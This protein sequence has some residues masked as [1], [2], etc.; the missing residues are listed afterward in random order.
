MLLT[1]RMLCLLV[2]FMLA[3][4][5]EGREGAA[6]EGDKTSGSSGHTAAQADKAKPRN[7]QPQEGAHAASTASKTD[8][9]GVALDLLLVSE[10]ELDDTNAISLLFNAPLD[11]DQ[12]FISGVNTT[13]DLGSPF[14]SPDGKTLYFNGIKPDTKYKVSFT[15]TIKAQNG[16]QYK[17]KATSSLTTRSMP[18][19]VSFESQGAILRPGGNET[20]PVL[21]QNVSDADLRIYRVRHEK[22]AR[23]FGAYTRLAN[24]D[25][26]YI[27]DLRNELLTETY[28]GRVHLANKKN[29]RNQ[30]DIAL[31]S[32]G[33]SGRKGLY[34][35]VVGQAGRFGFDSA[36][37]F[38]VSSLGMQLR[39][40][41]KSMSLVVQDIDG[42]E[43]VAD[44]SI[45][46]FKTAKRG[47]KSKLL[48]LRSD[49]E[50]GV[51]NEKGMYQVKGL[52]NNKRD[53]L[54]VATLG[55]QVSVLPYKE[56]KLDLS[57]YPI[58]GRSYA[59][60]E[61]FL[62]GPRDIYRPGEDLTV[63]ILRRDADGGQVPGPLRL[64]VIKPDASVYKSI[65]LDP[66]HDGYF[67]LE[68]PL[69]TNSPLGQWHADV[70][71]AAGKKRLAR[72]DFKVEEFLPERLRLEFENSSGGDVKVL[73]EYLYGAPAA[74]NAMDVRVTIRPW[75]SP[76][77]QHPG[78]VFGDEPKQPYAEEDLA[79]LTLDDAGKQTLSA[80]ALS[81][82]KLKKW[83]SPARLSYYC[84]LYESGGRA[85]NRRH[86]VLW[87]PK[88]S[89]IGIKPQFKNDRSSENSVAAFDVLRSNSAGQVLGSGQAKVS[90]IRH[91]KNYY[92][93]NTNDGWGYQADENE[94]VV[95]QQVIDFSEASKQTLE[96]PVEWGNYRL[97]IHDLTSQAD[98]V[99][100]FQAGSSWYRSWNTASSRIR[101][102]QVTLAWDQGGYQAGDTAT[103]KIAAPTAGKALVML[104][105]D[106]I[107]HQQFVDLKNN[108][109]TVSL[110]VPKDLNRH[111][112]YVSVY[113]VAP[114]TAGENVTKRSLGVIHLPLQ[115]ADRHL[116]VKIN[117]PERWRPEQTVTA[118][119]LVNNAKGQP[120]SGSAYVTLSA[121]DSG[122]LSLTDYKVSDPFDLFYAKRRYLAAI[123]DN[124][125]YVVE[126]L[127]GDKAKVLWGGDTDIQ[128]LR[129]KP[130]VDVK[131]VSLFS[132][133]VS[134]ANGVAKIPLDL[135]QFDGELTLTAVGFSG[136][137]FGKADQT[138]KVSAP[139]VAQLSKPRFLALGD[140][141][142]LALDL[143]N[144]N[145]PELNDVS[146]KYHIDGAL[147]QHHGQFDDIQLDTGKRKTFKF[148]ID[149][150][151]VGQGT[152]SVDI[153]LPGYSMR[154]TWSLNVR[155]AYPAEY[156][157]V[158]R[159]I[160]SGEAIAFPSE[161]LAGLMP[162]TVKAQIAIAQYPDLN[163]GEHLR[164]LDVYPYT[165][166]EQTSSKARP[167]ALFGVDEL[168]T[169]GLPIDKQ[170]VQEKVDTTLL[171]Y[172][173]LQRSN[174]SFGL[175]SK[176]SSEDQ[177]LTVYATELLLSLRD[178]GYE[179]P[180][181][182]LDPALARLKQYVR[183]NSVPVIKTWS[184]QPSHY[185]ASYRAYAAYVLAKEG[186]TT[187]GPVRSIA[188]NDLADA[189]GPLPSLRTGMAMIQLGAVDEG[190]KLIKTAM[191]LSR[192]SE[193]LGDYGSGVRDEAIV[194]AAVLSQQ[195]MPDGLQVQAHERLQALSHRIQTKSWLS[196]QERNAIIELGAV[197]QRVY[198]DTWSGDLATLAG[199]Q[200]L[201]GTGYKRLNIA[202]MLGDK[203]ARFVN[204]G[205]D[206]V[207][208]S[209]AWTGQRDQPPGKASNGIQIN[210]KHFVYAQGKA[211]PLQNGTELNT[212]DIVL[213][214][215]SVRSDE[216][217]PDALLVNLMPA[218]LELENQN[219]T[220]AMKLSS[221]RIEGKKL[222][223][224]HAIE[225]QEYRDDRY[226]AA[227]DLRPNDEEVVYFISRA[228]NPGQ[229][230]VPPA[231]IESMYSPQINGLGASMGSITVQGR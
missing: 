174:G 117:V 206:P 218:G 28:S 102:D 70:M 201:Q 30:V 75:A 143:T 227:M 126:R 122:V 31:D 62:Y 160:G 52:P 87:W 145:E 166:L 203:A 26:R 4:C 219:L 98:T 129:D 92:W 83:D 13:P 79:P 132:G 89:Y 95:S 182:M 103:L 214:R 189:A 37:W 167:F 116:D 107:L 194:L 151:N 18:P 82:I 48:N 202:Y 217:I 137:A 125:R 181:S 170:A 138:V 210:A 53:L 108:Q 38:T 184:N 96:L 121:V 47:N 156:H 157:R 220:H 159:S 34:F 69:P 3:A 41:Q 195:G 212:G 168:T 90:L 46:I 150:Q 193:Y 148:E 158:S 71:N 63:S 101:P 152:I 33:V 16:S 55:D 60:A 175:W 225:Y 19:G 196:P 127:L 119:V 164:Y 93:T 139:V 74:G 187:L 9:A 115:R 58:S 29:A 6:I 153:K 25:S 68:L 230:T 192:V 65:K 14:L 185:Y 50:V 155:S 76:L 133:Q 85:L 73:G 88:E 186:Q 171:R 57:E 114:T 24:P 22:V 12:D 51:T 200:A 228:I 36:T 169:F 97:K 149:A 146:V 204:T 110:P 136:S 172:A 17:S 198:T 67:E 118:K 1:K 223:N 35:A 176:S 100:A 77:E 209:Y 78:Y 134:V 154:R 61:H 56:P 226:M 213:S 222:H 207:F 94:Y 84:S 135:P 15:G 163:L 180:Q 42:G 221:I 179:V 7:N 54:F 231:Q 27:K 197:L 59:V 104:E 105:T 2:V 111:D 162:D 64:H 49:G 72:F 8:Y 147:V 141:S 91:E 190:I 211:A 229:Y 124:Y 205:K 44:A 106:R 5:G 40:N 11:P 177:W 144:L 131:I 208:V 191:G 178:A 199:E 66:Q 20:L 173:E 86:D 81:Q 109:A 165:C 80:S 113:V 43:P 140:K 21:A 128:E 215:V 112:A 123:K 10:R 120:F 183:S 130:P 45:Y 161:Q 23:F 32:L 142:T 99:Y 216:R 39:Q 224:S 188:E